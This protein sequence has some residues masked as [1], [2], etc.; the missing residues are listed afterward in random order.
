MLISFAKNEYVA[1]ILLAT[2]GQSNGQMVKWSVSFTKELLFKLLSDENLNFLC[3]CE[4]EKEVWMSSTFLEFTS[5]SDQSCT[6]GYS[7]SSFILFE[8]E[9]RKH[10]HYKIA[11]RGDHCE[12][13]TDDQHHT[14]QR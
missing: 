14:L 13:T 4:E 2:M 3:K 12:E 5:F 11:K 10:K 8:F 1:V 9:F 7:Y 6:S